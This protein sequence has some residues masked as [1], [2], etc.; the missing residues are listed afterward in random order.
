MRDAT[1][2]GRPGR[3]GSAVIS[4]ACCFCGLAVPAPAQEAAAREAWSFDV[5]PYLWAPRIDLRT[6]LSTLPPSEPPEEERFTT[7]LT[8]AALLTVRAHHG[9]WGGFADLVYAKVRSEGT[10]RGALYSQVR[11]DAEIAHATVAGTYR[12]SSGPTVTTEV[13]AGARLWWVDETLKFTGGVLPEYVTSGGDT[14]LDPL[15]GVD[16]AY[17]AS[18]DW[19]L[20]AMAT[21]SNLGSGGSLA[22]EAFAGVGYRVNDRFS[23]T[24]GYRYLHE[25]FA[26]RDFSLDATFQGVLVGA[27][28]HL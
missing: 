9:A 22:V 6:S 8:G 24:A 19:R 23:A 14:W 25:D 13:L 21:L 15:V 16:V 3:T 4:L 11:L 28:F 20:G 12:L 17:Q 18:P 10:A 27:S 7:S 26:N 5:T 1:G 2:R